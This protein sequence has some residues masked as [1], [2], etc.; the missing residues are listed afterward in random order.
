MVAQCHPQKK[1]G[2]HYSQDDAV[3]TVLGKEKKRNNFSDRNIPIF[4]HM[5]IA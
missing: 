4:T 1:T 3:L 2:G 5:G